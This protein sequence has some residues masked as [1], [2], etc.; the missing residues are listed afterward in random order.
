MARKKKKMPKKPK[1][2]SSIVTIKNWEKRAAA[3]N[4]Y[5]KKIEADKAAKQKILSKY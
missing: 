5:N 3:V 1:V 2:S 4:A